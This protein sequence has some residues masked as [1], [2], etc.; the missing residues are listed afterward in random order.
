MGGRVGWWDSKFVALMEKGKWSVKTVFS[1]NGRGNTSGLTWFPGTLSWSAKRKQLLHLHLNLDFFF[2]LVCLDE[3]DMA[4]EM[5]EAG[6]WRATWFLPGSLAFGMLVFRIQLPSSYQLTRLE[7]QWEAHMERQKPHLRASI[8][9]IRARTKIRPTP[10]L[11]AKPR[12]GSQDRWCLPFLPCLDSTPR[13]YEQNERVFCTT[14]CWSD[15]N[16]LQTGQECEGHQLYAPRY[17]GNAS[18]LWAGR[19]REQSK[20]GWVMVDLRGVSGV[21]ERPQSRGHGGSREMFLGQAHP[22]PHPHAEMS[23]KESKKCESILIM[24]NKHI[25]LYFQSD[26]WKFHKTWLQC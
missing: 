4:E 12:H 6:L 24:S 9:Q 3:Q 15:Y 11:P 25:L 1:K 16:S 5:L 22:S 17:G 18:F 14:T 13:I 2:F 26:I 23:Y 8:S 7:D 21:S 20:T 19:W 10:G